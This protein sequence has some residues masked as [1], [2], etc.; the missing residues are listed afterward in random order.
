M[1][2]EGLDSSIRTG[3]SLIRDAKLMCQM[4]WVNFDLNLMAAGLWLLFIH[5][6]LLAMAAAIPR[7]RLISVVI[8]NR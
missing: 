3:L 1:T 6:C 2:Q 7:N 4:V 5:T 8:N